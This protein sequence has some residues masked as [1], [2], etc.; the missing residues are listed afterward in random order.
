MKKLLFLLPFLG[1][2]VF[3]SAQTNGTNTP[4]K[5]STA[6]KPAKPAAPKD[7]SLCSK[8]WDLIA[9]EEW[10]V[11][12]KPKKKQQDDYLWMTGDGKYNLKRNGEA[13]AGTWTRTGAYINFTDDASKEKFTYKVESAEAKKL[14]VDY[15]VSDM[16]T[17]FTFEV[18]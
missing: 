5:T 17:L 16:H 9:V 1:L 8:R 12:S 10:A 7:T 3:V 6:A 18:K 13:K 2:T 14:K 11:E 4:A 15:H